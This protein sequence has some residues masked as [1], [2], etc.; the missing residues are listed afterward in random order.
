M[1]CVIR[2]VNL[3]PVSTDLVSYTCTLTLDSKSCA[4]L[5]PGS[6]HI[7]YWGARHLRG[8]VSFDEIHYLFQVGLRRMRKGCSSAMCVR[9][10]TYTWRISSGWRLTP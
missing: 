1:C 7:H 4:L 2:V 5:G 6:R 8:I 10:A 3:G 9:A